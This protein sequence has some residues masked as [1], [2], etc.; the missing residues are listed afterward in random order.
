MIEVT[1]NNLGGDMT[2]QEKATRA[3]MRFE[4][5][6]AISNGGSAEDLEKAVDRI[7]AI[8]EANKPKPKSVGYG[9]VIKG[10]LH[11]TK[12][13]AGSVGFVPLYTT[14]TTRDPLSEEQR[15]KIVKEMQKEFPPLI[16]RVATL[17]IELTEQA[18]EIGVTK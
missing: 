6:K 8:H 12:D 16:S 18:H 7:I 17:V 9:L 10:V 5:E 14:P 1:E 4:I 11:A 15:Q 3:R 2:N 13:E